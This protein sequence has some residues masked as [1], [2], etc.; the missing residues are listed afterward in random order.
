MAAKNSKKVEPVRKPYL[1]GS[2]H[3]A[4]ARKLALRCMLAGLILTLVLALSSMIVSMN[5]V[6][7]RLLIVLLFEGL[8]FYYRFMQGGAQGEADVTLGEIMYRRQENGQPIASQDRDR[9]FHKAKGFFAVAL[10]MLPFF[11]FTLI[12][13]LIA[14]P[15]SFTL[16]ALPSWMS[17]LRYQ[18]E[19][20]DAL[21]YYNAAGQMGALDVMRVI[22]RVLILPWVTA[23]SPLGNSALTLAEKLSPLLIW[24]APLGYGFG[25]LQGVSRR[26]AV[27]TG[28][29][30]GTQRRE[31]RE[32]KAL[33]QR[34]RQRQSK[35]P[36]Q[37]I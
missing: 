26:V 7:L 36:E 21:Q 32:K 25:Y 19:M 9:C 23:L 10:G 4:D 22:D 33:K 8:C 2:W 12:Y 29:K 14:K 28:I 6:W 3:G 31:R 16:G 35:Q 13:A 17:D 37:L 18:T 20:G 34:Q 27:N 30:E 11:V 15:V 1:T 5:S 24:V